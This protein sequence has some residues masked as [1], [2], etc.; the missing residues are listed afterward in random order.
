M[1]RKDFILREIEKISILLLYLIGKFVPSK[2]IEKQQQTE[3]L[4]NDE[5]RET[6]GNDLNYLLTLDEKDFE[7]E[8]NQSKGFNFENI[9][10]LADLLYTIGNDEMKTKPDYLQKALH[11]YEYVDKKSKTFSFERTNK[12]NSIHDLM[13]LS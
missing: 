2:S 8:F 10:L 12:M 4:I 11:I 13:T 6:F 9:E 1:E 3:K 7:T 5:L